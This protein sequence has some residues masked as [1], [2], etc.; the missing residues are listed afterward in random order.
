MNFTVEQFEFFLVILV[1][2]TGFVY[3]APF[4]SLKNTPRN[5]K[6]GFSLALAIL[7]FTTIPYQ[8]LVYAGVIGYAIEVLEEALAGIVLGF[9]ANV[10]YQMLGFAGQLIDTEIGLS[11]VNEF[12]PVTN[13]QVTISGTF[14]QYGVMLMLMV[15]YMHHFLLDALVDSFKLIPVGGVDFNPLIYELSVKYI[16]DYFIIAFRIVLPVFAAMLIVNT[17]LAIMAK[18]APQMNMFVI[19]IQLKVLVGLAVMLIVIE[20]LPGVSNFI[21]DEM[22]DLMRMAVPY[23]GG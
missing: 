22:M 18:V 19:G 8:P 11:M 9:L 7:I 17:I 4:F 12:D 16:V 1:R 5:L 21:F 6:T 10:C 20:L 15:T 3:T 14:Y 23:L 13:G 2:I